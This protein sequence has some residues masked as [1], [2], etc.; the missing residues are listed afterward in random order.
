VTGDPWLVT[1]KAQAGAI[2]EARDARRIEREAPKQRWPKETKKGR[3]DV[4]QCV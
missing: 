3:K 2:R 4:G 1:R